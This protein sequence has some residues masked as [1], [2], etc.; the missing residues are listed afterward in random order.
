MCTYVGPSRMLFLE[1]LAPQAT[2]ADI[3]EALERYGDV[4]KVIILRKKHIHS[5]PSDSSKN[6]QNA[7]VQMSNLDDA[8]AAHA[9]N[10][11]PVLLQVLPGRNG[12]I[13]MP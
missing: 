4:D 5:S 8:I 3:E 10:D 13:R 6:T 2:D 1:N 12:Q 11:Q 7:L 9:G